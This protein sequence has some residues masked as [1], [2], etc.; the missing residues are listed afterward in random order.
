MEMQYFQLHLN[1]AKVQNSEIP[2]PSCAFVF[3]LILSHFFLK[4]SL[5]LV[6]FHPLWVQLDVKDNE[7]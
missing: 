5:H 2:Y 7:Q 3:Q 1:E 6:K 4:D